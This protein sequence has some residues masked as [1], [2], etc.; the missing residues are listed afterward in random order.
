MA[1]LGS[2][3][4]IYTEIL[5]LSEYG[6]CGNATVTKCKVCNQVLEIETHCIG[7]GETSCISVAWNM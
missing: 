1:K 6:A 3:H 5:D 7:D 2:G 4:M